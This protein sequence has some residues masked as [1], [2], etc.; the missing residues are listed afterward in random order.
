[1]VRA[2]VVQLL[3]ECALLLID[4]CTVSLSPLSST[5][6]VPLQ[7]NRKSTGREGGDLSESN[8]TRIKRQNEVNLNARLVIW[9]YNV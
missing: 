6:P 9:R 4:V 5:E 8:K 1:M 3:F 7:T 2:P